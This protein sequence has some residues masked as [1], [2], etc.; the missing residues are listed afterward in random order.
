MVQFTPKRILGLAPQDQLKA[1]RY[2]SLGSL[3]QFIKVALGRKRLTQNLHFPICSGLEKPFIKDVFEI[4][5][6]HFKSTICT[7]GLPIWWALPFMKSDEDMFLK[8]GYPDEWIRWMA[9][10]HNAN[11]RPLLVSE[12]IT[13]AAKL[14]KKVRWHFESNALYRTLFPET[15]PTP[16]DIWTTFS[17]HVNR[18]QFGSGGSHGEGTFDFI[19]VGGAL[20]SRHYDAVVQDDLVGRK[21]IDS[22]VIMES[23]IEYHKLLVGA[24]DSQDANHENNEL[25]IGNRWSF[26]DLNSYIRENEDWFNF[27]S[28]SAL[29]GCCALHPSD[30][31]IF[32]E[33]FSAEKLLKFKRRLGSYHFSCQFLNNPV[34]PEDADFQPDWLRYFTVERDEQGRSVIKHE[35]KDG[36]VYKDIIVGHLAIAMSVDP[37]HAG[38][39]AAGRCR[40]SIMVVGKAEPFKDDKSNLP[41]FYLLD[42]WAGHTNYSN[43]VDEIYKRCDKFRLRKFGLETV[44]AQKYLKFYLDQKN[45]ADGRSLRILELK[46]EVEAPDGSLTKKKEWRIRNV[47]AP[48][49]EN[50]QFWVQKKQQDFIGEYSTFPRGKFVD[51]LDALA[52]IPQMLKYSVSHSRSFELLQHN[53]E[54]AMRVNTPYSSPSNVL[55]IH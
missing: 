43:F 15:L 5:R 49:F 30:T 28:H 9:S 47:L 45:L 54:Q 16:S 7:E 18:K 39:A 44:A 20:Q 36:I 24:F 34:S 13:N 26:N 52:Y 23:T 35:T 11:Q 55:R 48:L 46:G 4:P 10:V 25:V 33:E 53:Q 21:S 8:E 22:P 42:A 31:P 6:D 50:G 38:N 41:R 32:P 14:G 40:H 12:N 2:N 19:G 37:N 27:H 1:I 17:L 29:G 51:E 3:Y